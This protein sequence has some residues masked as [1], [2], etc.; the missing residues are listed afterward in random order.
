LGCSCAARVG[1]VAVEV[2][3]LRQGPAER[4]QRLQRFVAARVAGDAEMRPIG[5]LDGDF[6]ALLQAERLDD[7]G[8]EAD[9]EAVAPAA[10]LDGIPLRLDIPAIVYLTRRN[11]QV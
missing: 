1:L 4:A 8:G 5:G 9:G 7:G 2:E 6:V 10:D 11:G 3:T